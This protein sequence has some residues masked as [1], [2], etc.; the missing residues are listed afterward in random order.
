MTL[1]SPARRFLLVLLVMVIC[2]GATEAAARTVAVVY[3]DSGSMTRPP[4]KWWQANYALQTLTALLTPGDSLA[5]VFMSNPSR[6]IPW[7][8]KQRAIR[9]LQEQAPPKSNTPFQ[10]LETAMQALQQ[11]RDADR[12]LILITDGGFNEYPPTD[13]LEANITQFAADTGTKAIFL[14]IGT[15]VSDDLAKFWDRIATAQIFRAATPQEIGPRMQEIAAL[16]NGRPLSPGELQLTSR[17]N[18][19]TLNVEM[20]LKRLTVFQQEESGQALAGIQQAAAGTTPLRVTGLKAQMPRRAQLRKYAAATHITQSNPDQVIPA[21]S[22]TITL[23]RSVPQERLHF[24]PEV[25]A[26]FELSLEQ[27]DGTP[28][29]A[30][31]Q[32]EYRACI[33]QPVRLVALLL[34]PVS[35]RP[36][37]ATIQHYDKITV[38]ASYRQKDYPLTLEPGK[39][40]FSVLIP[41]QAGKEPLAAS[42]SFPGYF[43]FKSRVFIL[44]G[45]ACPRDVALEPVPP[46]SAKVNELPQASPVRLR[47]TVNGRPVSPAEFQNWTLTIRQAP[48]VALQIDKA[49]DHWL[50]R[51]QGSRISCCFTPTGRMPVEV[52]ISTGPPGEIIREQLEL[53]IEDI[54]WWSKC[55]WLV[56]L[57]I[58]L[59]IIAWWVWGILKKHRFARGAA[60]EFHWE[61]G[62]QRGRPRTQAL[63]TSF[64]QRWLVPYRAERRFVEGVLFIAG[65]RSNHVLVAKSS[66]S[67]GMDID[68]RPVW[69]PGSPSAPKKDQR[70]D[71]NSILHRR[72]GQ[73]TEFYKYIVS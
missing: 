3:D 26:L 61:K 10:A 56:I 35:R 58:T 66:L 19:I 47:P 23:D 44:E 33:G 49:A 57:V 28:L 4:E 6:A 18:Q 65:S 9:D 37:S 48:Q 55:G 62:E 32:N 39:Q 36:L 69:E 51:P 68:G 72:Q 15:E 27:E 73:T 31:P 12:W 54:S 40:F 11:S 38:V 29:A 24:F 53:T 71:N 13:R 7:P 67:A 52:E 64:W 8:D 45:I 30:T 16:V 50:L 59:L 5:V 1:S 25:A 63:P 46:W 14:L 70:L 22:L 60:I 43:H 41:V 2:W 34:D 21:G 20:P 17:G 42:A